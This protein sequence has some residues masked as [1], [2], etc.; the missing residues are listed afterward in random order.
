MLVTPGIGSAND[1]PTLVI[2]GDS[3]SAGYGL[4][5]GEGWTD[6][7]AARLASQGYEHRVINASIS[8]DTT[9]GGRARL[10]HA[11][12][13]HNP[14]LVIIELGGNDG[15]R[16]F[17]IE[18]LKRNLDA[19][20][21]AAA[22]AGAELVILGMRIPENYGARY[23]N[24]FFNVFA[25]V[26]ERYDAAYV[27]FFLEGVAEDPT[28]MQRDGIHPTAQAQAVMLDTAWPAIQSKLSKR[29]AV[30]AL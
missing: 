2:V 6:L 22:A 14:E 30:E 11:L 21:E 12:K 5:L 19:M 9:S 1:S 16:G 29:T 18:I 10:P 17:D 15:L 20:A 7:L 24:A 27:P 23:T 25:D 13:R 26:A 28:L 3:L 8:G 4:D